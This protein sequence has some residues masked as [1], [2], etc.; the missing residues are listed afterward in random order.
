MALFFISFKVSASE[1][2]SKVEYLCTDHPQ[3]NACC[4][5]G[6]ACTRGMPVVHWVPGAHGERLSCTGS[7]VQ[8]VNACRALDPACTR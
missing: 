1:R 5:L 6:P 4:A 3:T 7:R 8:K 2:L